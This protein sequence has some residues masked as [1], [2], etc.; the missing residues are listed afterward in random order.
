MATSLERGSIFVPF[1]GFVAFSPVARGFLATDV[2][3]AGFD[4]K[5]IRRAMPRFAPE[6]LAAN[7]RWLPA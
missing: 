6:H 1:A 7:R 3:P 2:D 4:A 5:D